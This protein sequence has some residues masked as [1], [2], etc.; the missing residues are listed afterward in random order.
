MDRTVSLMDLL[1]ERGR[2]DPY[3]FYARLHENG[4]AVALGPA[5]KFAA[6][7]HGFSAVDR[8]LR[9]PVFR[10][11]GPE[12]MDRGGT[13]WRQHSVLRTM[14]A[15]MFNA[16]GDGHARARRL[17]GQAFSVRR[18]P[19]LEQSIVS[20][21]DR[22]LDRLAGLGAGGRPVD[23]MSAFA[24]T[25]PSDVIGEFL[26][27]PAVDRAWFP[28][29]VRTFDAILEV[30]QRSL[31]QVKEAD[32]AADELTA[33]FAGLLAA[34][35]AD[36]RDDLITDLARAGLGGPDQ[37]TETEVLAN[38]I[39]MFN[40]GFRTTANL[41]GTGLALLLEHPDALAA[42]RA[43]PD[44]APAY[45]EEILRFEPPVH[46]AIRYASR[47]TEVAG[48][49]VPEGRSVLVLTAAANRD[50]R[51]FPDPDRFDPARSDNH[52]FGFGA[53]PHYCLGA[54]LGR[55]EGRLALPRLLDRFPRLAL[56][57]DPPERR[58]LMLRGFDELP[59]LVG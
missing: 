11:L 1:G 17:F 45:V 51:R 42:L 35:R 25:L 8:V 10:V 21:T 47:D 18:V 19:A 46:F 28:A 13:R 57:A 3:P 50:P 36:P 49:H 16:S 6:I 39:V 30:G 5:A 31:R 33:Y 48:V 26:G 37:L 59:V 34:R 55:A 9:D 7:V 58:N 2:R 53:G 40:A 56:A 38:L 54:A 20:T 32:V 14:Q 44:S 29:R 4:E 15:S 27:V 41:L 52:H 23:F 24:L 22:L 43:D 12:Y